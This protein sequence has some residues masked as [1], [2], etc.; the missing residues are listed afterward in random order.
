[1]KKILYLCVIFIVIVCSCNKSSESKSK[2]DNFE[3]ESIVYNDSVQG[4]F[5]KTP[6]GASKEEVI[7]NFKAH[8]YIVNK[9][10]STDQQLHFYPEKGTR[11][12]FGNMSWDMLTVYF[13]NNKF[14]T[15]KFMN[16]GNDKASAIKDYENILSTVSAKYNMM[17]EEPE[18]TTYY[19]QAVGYSKQNRYIIVSCYRYETIG[20]EIKQ[21]VSLVYEDQ[22]F[23]NEVSGEL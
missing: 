8:G 10:V 3:N 21:G 6:F 13:N 19:R 2:N 20:R 4:V 23:D 12:T 5:F 17:E 11:F 18:D 16:A 1:M 7:A 9:V 15:I 14:C 22:D